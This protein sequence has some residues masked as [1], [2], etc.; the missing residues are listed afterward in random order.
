[1]GV[2]GV[3]GFAHRLAE[4]RKERL[5]G[6]EEEQEAITQDVMSK[7]A[8][9]VMLLGFTRHSGAARELR[10]ELCAQ[11]LPN[12]KDVVGRVVLW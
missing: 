2:S 12:R 7:C 3:R 6:R 11:L 10:L 1:M 5:E 4:G 8:S 9:S